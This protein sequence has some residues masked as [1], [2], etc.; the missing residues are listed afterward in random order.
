MTTILIIEDEAELS[1]ALKVKFERE[2]F[3][4]SIAEDGEDGLRI[5]LETHPDLIVLDIN[6][7]KMDGL[8]MLKHLRKDEWGSKVPVI[9]LTNNDSVEKMADAAEFEA[10]EYILKTKIKLDDLVSNIKKRLQK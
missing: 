9:L 1:N 3:A 5:A 10:L 2:D 4:V 6:M 8:T 7:P